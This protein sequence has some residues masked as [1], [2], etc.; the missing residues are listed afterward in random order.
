MSNPSAMLKQAI[1]EMKLLA[2]AEDMADCFEKWANQIKLTFSGWEF[3]RGM[4]SDGGHIFFGQLKGQLLV[5]S[6]N[7]QIYKG[8]NAFGATKIKI[9]NPITFEIDYN[10]LNKIF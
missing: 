6:P 5:I 7:G 2:T 3:T 1:E 9:G 4:T 8:N 10:K